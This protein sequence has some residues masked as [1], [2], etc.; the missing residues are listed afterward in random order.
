MKA[1]FRFFAVAVLMVVA[2]SCTKPVSPEFAVLACDTTLRCGSAEYAVLYRFT[3]IANA[4]SSAALQAIEEANIHYFFGLEEFAGT[5]CEAVQ[6]ALDR[7]LQEAQDEPIDERAEADLAGSFRRLYNESI[8]ADAAVIDTLLVYT[9]RSSGYMGGAHGMYAT[10][11]HNYS[12]A[13]GYEI[14]LSDLFTA[15]QLSGLDS[16]IRNRLYEQF[17]VTGDEGLAEQGFFPE[18]IRPTENFAVSERGITF[19]Y[20]PYDIGCYALG[21]VSLEIGREE[22]NRLVDR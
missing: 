1:L 20:N 14:T 2:V 16:L 22:L 12:L 13:G 17:G 4:S 11:A 7:V 15:G 18:Y 6:A 5:A 21:D 8:E 19:Y 3:T 9:I 10:T